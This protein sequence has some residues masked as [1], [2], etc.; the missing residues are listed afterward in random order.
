MSLINVDGFFET[1]TGKRDGRRL[2]PLPFSMQSVTILIAS[3]TANVNVVS[4]SSFFILSY[5]EGR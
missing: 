1:D 2:L 3:A 5:D 4:D